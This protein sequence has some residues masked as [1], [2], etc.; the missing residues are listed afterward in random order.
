[1]SSL[2]KIQSYALSKPKTRATAQRKNP[3][4]PSILRDRSRLR[5]SY[6]LQIHKHII[7]LMQYIQRN[8]P[9]TSTKSYYL[10]IY[11]EYEKANS[12]TGQS[13]VYSYNA[14][15]FQTRAKW[16]NRINKDE[17]FYIF[18]SNKS[19]TWKFILSKAPWSGGLND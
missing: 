1:M 9:R 2:C 6:V 15:T 14:K 19:I 18:L 13:E 11:R 10:R 5:T 7:I 3:R 12:K 16:L 8:S 17:E 4:I